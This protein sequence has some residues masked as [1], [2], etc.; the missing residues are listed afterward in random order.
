VYQMFTHMY[1]SVMLHLRDGPWYV[2]SDME[3]GKPRRRMYNNLQGKVF[4]F[5]GGIFAWCGLMWVTDVGHGCGAR[6]W[7]TDVGHGCG[8]W[9]CLTGGLTD[10]L[11]G[12]LTNGITD[13][14]PY[15][16]YCRFY[17]L[18]FCFAFR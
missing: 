18:Y 9:V 2:N 13:H 5:G 14:K 1:D 17:L 10:G 15:F 3:S 8:S 7:G 11:M 6:M 16:S 12:G 4:V